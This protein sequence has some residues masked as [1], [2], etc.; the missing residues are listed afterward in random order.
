MGRTFEGE[1]Q[2]VGQ[3]DEGHRHGR[4][5]AAPG[6]PQPPDDI[7]PVAHR[8]IEDEQDDGHHRADGHDDEDLGAQEILHGHQQ[9]ESDAHRHRSSPLAHQE[10]VQA[11]HDEGHQDEDPRHQVS[12][13]QV[14]EDER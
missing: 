1:P 5:E 14:D 4:A 12:A 8:A 10:L 13:G 7:A 6:R 11:P 3:E 9:A 2:R